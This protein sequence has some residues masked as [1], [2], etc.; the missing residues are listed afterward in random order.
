[1]K[2]IKKIFLENIENMF[3]PAVFLLVNE[4]KKTA[5]ISRTGCLMDGVLRMLR[6]IKAGDH[7]IKDLTGY[8][9]LYI[10]VSSDLRY[11]YSSICNEYQ[12]A[13]YILLNRTI[14]YR[15]KKRT[16][17][18]AMGY[19]TQVVLGTRNYD[20]KVLGEFATNK[21]AEGFIKQWRATN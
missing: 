3:F 1:M 20:I 18:N 9:L 17:S 5:W 10:D 19:Y 21:E 12:E 14:K 6:S 13:G 8:K 15:I 7:R 16:R 2:E 4:E 11:K